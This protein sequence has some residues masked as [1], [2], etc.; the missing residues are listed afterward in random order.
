MF[1]KKYLNIEPYK[2][3]NQDYYNISISQQN[4]NDFY[5]DVKNYE[6]FDLIFNNDNFHLQIEINNGKYT[7]NGW[8]DNRLFLNNPHY[9]EN[10]SAT[11]KNIEQVSL[12]IYCDSTINIENFSDLKINQP[13]IINDISFENN[14]WVMFKGKRFNLYSDLWYELDNK[15]YFCCF[16]EGQKRYDSLG[17][18]A[19]TLAISNYKFS[20]LTETDKIIYLLQ[21]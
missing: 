13:T 17:Y 1:F 18:N 7:I 10:T 11:V 3:F 9:N 16:V 20:K 19:E 12:K 8:V 5:N 15:T 2:Q 4:R 6:N 14:D 21:N